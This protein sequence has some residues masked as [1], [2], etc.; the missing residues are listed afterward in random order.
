MNGLFQENGEWFLRFYAAQKNSEPLSRQTELGKLSQADAEAAAVA[1]IIKIKSDIFPDVR[2]AGGEVVC[3][4]NSDGWIT[5]TAQMPAIVDLHETIRSELQKIGT[6]PNMDRTRSHQ[7]RPSKVAIW[8]RSSQFK[9]WERHWQH[10]TPMR[11]ASCCMT[12]DTI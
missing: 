9:S 2:K 3:W 6:C 8:I 5:F 7:T 11:R 4:P 1:A 10:R 12:R